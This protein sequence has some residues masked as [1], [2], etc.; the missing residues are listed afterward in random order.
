MKYGLKITVIDK[1]CSV[2]EKYLTV[3]KVILYGS[4]AIGNYRIGSDID[5]ALKGNLTE[6]DY[7]NILLELDE[8]ML[9][10]MMDVTRLSSI[11]NQNLIEHI[12]R[13]GVV[14]YEQTKILQ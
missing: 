9:P 10:Y 12:N 3:E 6:R 4:R 14:F 2:F 7:Y 5:F 13:R 11:E 8:L 1:I